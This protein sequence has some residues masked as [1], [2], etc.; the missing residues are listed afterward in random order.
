MTAKIN[1]EGASVRGQGLW[2]VSAWVS[3]SNDGE[4]KR[5]SYTEQVMV[6]A[7]RAVYSPLFLKHWT[8]V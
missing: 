8:V 1:E 3:A 5:I 4:G 6:F 7:L 2:K